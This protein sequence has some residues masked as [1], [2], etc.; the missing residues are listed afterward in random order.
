[1]KLEWNLSND[2]IGNTPCYWFF[3]M[4]IL[5]KIS[6]ANLAKVIPMALRCGAWSIL[7]V[8][9]RVVF[10]TETANVAKMVLNQDTFIAYLKPLLEE[11][12][13]LLNLSYWSAIIYPCFREAN[14]MVL[15]NSGCN[16]LE[17]CYVSRKFLSRKF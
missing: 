7:C 4:V 12:I 14:P 5:F 16:I 10:E 3:F 8:L 13:N 1:M 2:S 17:Q 15:F 9:N 6:I 11:V